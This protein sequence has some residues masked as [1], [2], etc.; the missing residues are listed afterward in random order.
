M[1][2]LGVVH[3]N[4]TPMSLDPYLNQGQGWHRET[5]LKFIQGR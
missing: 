5:S 4:Q 2:K 1:D 3:A